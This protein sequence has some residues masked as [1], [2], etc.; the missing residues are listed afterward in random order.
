MIFEICVSIIDGKTYAVIPDDLYNCSDSYELA[1]MLDNTFP[2]QEHTI[3]C[4]GNYDNAVSL[5]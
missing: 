1:E 2:T 3:V 4:F 5:N